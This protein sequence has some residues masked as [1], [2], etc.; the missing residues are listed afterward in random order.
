AGKTTFF[1]L[2]T[3]FYKPEEGRIFF[4][5]EDITS[6]PV[7]KII[8]KGISRSFQVLQLFENFTVLENVWIGVQ[9]EKGYGKEI[10]SSSDLKD[11]REKAVEMIKK[12]GLSD[13][14]DIPI[15]YLSHGERRMV[16]VV[17]SL[18][19]NPELLLLDEPMAGL[20]SEE[21]VR[22]S[23]FI[24][25]LSKDVTIVVV[26]HDMDVVFSISDKIAV[27]HQ[28]E[29]IAVGSPEEVRQNEKVQQAYLG[30]AR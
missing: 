1:N 24:K 9:A 6:L 19:S 29:L 21:R 5:E 4:K 28:G 25:D 22:M 2:L 7:H 20:A 11:V 3:G 15:K 26:E 8:R 23:D 10:F 12:I 17:I 27:M 30:E 16:D 18:T 13:K 14:M